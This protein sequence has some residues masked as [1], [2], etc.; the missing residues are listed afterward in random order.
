VV[1]P[2]AE[3]EP[4]VRAAEQNEQTVIVRPK[5]NSQNDR[6]FFFSVVNP[7]TG[8]LC[9]IGI[10]DAEKNKRSELD[11]R[12][13]YDGPPALQGCSG[14]VGQM[15]K[16]APG[17]S[18]TV[19]AVIANDLGDKT[20]YTSRIPL[21]DPTDRSTLQYD[22]PLS[23][24]TA[25][26]DS[27]AEWISR[28]FGWLSLIAVVVGSFFSLLLNHAGPLVR[29]KLK[30]RAELNGID[31]EIDKIRHDILR[32]RM[33]VLRHEVFSKFYAIKFYNEES[34]NEAIDAEIK[35]LEERVSLA[36]KLDQH[37]RRL[38]DQTQTPFLLATTIEEEIRSGVWS[39]LNGDPE[40]AAARE[41]AIAG[42][43][44]KDSA[45]DSALQKRLATLVTELVNLKSQGSLGALQQTF[46]D[47]LT[48]LS[49]GVPALTA[50]DLD[51]QDWLSLDRRWFRLHLLVDR[52]D[53]GIMERKSVCKLL[54]QNK[55]DEGKHLE[56]LRKRL[57]KE[58]E[59]A[60]GDPLFAPLMM[61]HL[62]N[63]Q[64]LVREMETGF[65]P[66]DIIDRFT[67]ENGE[68]ACKVEIDP[69]NPRMGQ[70]VRFTLNMG[71]GIDQSFAARDL[72][73]DWDFGD[74]EKPAVGKRCF[75]YYKESGPYPLTVRVKAPGGVWKP[76]RL[77]DAKERG[78][79]VF[80]GTK[81]RGALW[82]LSYVQMAI[83]F[84]SLFVAILTAYVLHLSSAEGNS[85]NDLL[86]PFLIGVGIDQ[87]RDKIANKAI[88]VET[89]AEKVQKKE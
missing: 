53:R 78:L 50:G 32:L 29:N 68:D 19:T 52:F 6:T 47:D 85:F 75:H 58:L 8:R 67:G 34:E 88:K 71:D 61:E 62:R 5:S 23:V 1:R 30:W 89:L 81:S 46:E 14:T 33:R 25:F 79:R 15:A 54:C 59:L 83:F 42:Y 73:Y 22:L 36:T 24:A 18:R 70:T 66:E 27:L 74:G 44:A 72:L 11:V 63:A 65:L 77:A 7:D 20:T 51:R 55:P 45:R 49:A 17:D 13:E 40:A 80:V 56:K 41:K 57:V 21:Y 2:R 16:F 86:I 35:A 9:C 82:S 4:Q 31:E 60:G 87:V 43:F 3:F 69:P 84:A 10:A 39:L 28:H 64:R 12:F 38:A 37:S 26:T 76:V 48:A